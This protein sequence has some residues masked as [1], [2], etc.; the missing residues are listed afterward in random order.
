MSRRGG[1][2]EPA[3]RGDEDE[4]ARAAPLPRPENGELVPAEPGAR[5][6]PGGT[7]GADI[8][9]PGSAHLPE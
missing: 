9:I 5:P 6:A 8:T 3:G 7:D 4:T 2:G 1:F